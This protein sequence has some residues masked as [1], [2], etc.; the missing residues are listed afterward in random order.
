MGTDGWGGLHPIPLPFPD[1]PA[2]LPSMPL[3][4]RWEKS[5]LHLPK[6][7]IHASAPIG[8][9]GDV[10]RKGT[11]MVEIHKQFHLLFPEAEQVI[12]AHRGNAHLQRQEGSLTALVAE[13][14]EA[15]CLSPSNN[16]ASTLA[17]AG[18]RGAPSAEWE[19][20]TSRAE[21]STRMAASI[22]LNTIK[23]SP[24]EWVIRMRTLQSR[25]KS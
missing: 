8:G 25:K 10:L 22:S 19:A 23:C 16:W 6:E 9:R 11:S 4:N 5:L 17:M 1:T 13:G 15:G 20:S 12:S 21:A 24:R 7:R 2:P 14:T 18:G 3:L